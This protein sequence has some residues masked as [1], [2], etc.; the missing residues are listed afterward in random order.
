MARNDV[1]NGWALILVSFAVFS[2]YSFWVLILPI[3]NADHPC[4][5]NP[6][7]RAPARWKV[8][9]F[10]RPPLFLHAQY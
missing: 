10:W 8:C 2:Y 7:K 3:V 5:S 4:A 9:V 1:F 6:G